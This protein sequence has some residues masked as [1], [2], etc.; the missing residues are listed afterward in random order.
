VLA[1]REQRRVD[2]NLEKGGQTQVLITNVKKFE[3]QFFDPLTKEW[4]TNWDTTSAGA[5]P[6]R[7]PLQAKITI[8]VPNLSGKGPDQTFGTR[9]WFPI[10]YAMNF[11]LYKL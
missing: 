7:M 3:V 6:N 1:R 4:S 9:T 11:A 8:K 5:Q 2:E 10:T